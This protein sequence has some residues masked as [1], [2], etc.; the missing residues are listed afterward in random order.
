MKSDVET[1]SVMDWEPAK[2]VMSRFRQAKMV[3]D[4]AH[5]AIKPG[6]NVYKIAQEVAEDA[7]KV[8]EGPKTFLMSERA[9][10]MIMPQKIIQWWTM[11]ENV[12]VRKSGN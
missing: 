9:M 8:A 11:I 10:K 1:D 2:L 6:E 3:I 7:E 12:I 5:S 4:E